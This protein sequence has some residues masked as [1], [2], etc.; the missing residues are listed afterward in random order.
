[1]VELSHELPFLERY[2]CLSL[3]YV[4]LRGRVGGASLGQGGGR[5]SLLSDECRLGLSYL[6]PG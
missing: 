4:R 3:W 5:L 6:R 1:M 2:R